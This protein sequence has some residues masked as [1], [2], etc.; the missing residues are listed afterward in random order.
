LHLIKPAWSI[1]AC[2]LQL[3]N[4]FF[5]QSVKLSSLFL[6]GFDAVLGVWFPVLR[7][8]VVPSCAGSGNQ[9]RMLDPEDEGTT[10]L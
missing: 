3:C 9:R 5:L 1:Q 10:V 4:N 2:R 6:A 8:I 7:R